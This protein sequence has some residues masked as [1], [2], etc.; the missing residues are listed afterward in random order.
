[1]G[2]F[3]TLMTL[4]MPRTVN[5]EFRHEIG[6]R[7][8]RQDLIAETDFVIY[9]PADSLAFQKEQA[10]SIIN[11]IL[12][13]D[14]LALGRSIRQFD[15]KLLELTQKLEAVTPSA[16]ANLTDETAQEIDAFFLNEIGIP[17]EAFPQDKAWFS[18]LRRQGAYLIAAALRKGIILDLPESE[19]R[20]FVSVRVKPRE[21]VEIP[22]TSLWISQNDLERWIIGQ[23]SVSDQ[24]S[25]F[26]GRLIGG[27]IVP[28][29]RYESDWTRQAREEQMRWVSPIQRRVKKGTVILEKGEIVTPEVSDTIHAYAQSLR[30]IGGVEATIGRLIGRF[31]LIFLMTFLMLTFLRVNRPRIFFSNQR[32]SL[33]LTTLLLVVGAMVIATRLNDVA[34]RLFGQDRS[35]LNLSYIFLAP[36]CIVPIFMSNFF[37]HRV[38][39]FSNLVVTFCGAVLVQVGLEYAF[40]QLI[41]GTVAVYSLRRLRKR[42]VFFYTLGFIFLGYTTAYITFNLFAKGNLDAVNLNTILLFAINVLLT[43]IAYNLIYLFEQIFRVTSDLTYLELLDTNH[44]LLK[45]LARKAPGTFQHSLQVANLAEAAANEIG[46]NALLIHVG[47]LYHDIGKMAHPKYFIENQKDAGKKEA[48]HEKLS[49]QESAEM[50]IEHVRKGVTIAQKYHLP[51]ELIQFIQTHH[52]TT[53]VEYFYRMYLKETDHSAPEGEDLFRYP[54]PLPFS[55]ETAVLMIADSV[56]AAARSLKNP[57]VESLYELVDNIVDYKISEDQLVNSPLT[58]YDIS[59][60]REVLKE[61]MATIYHGRIEYPPEVSE[62]QTPASRS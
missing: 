42:E 2:G 31:F 52:G 60:I 40:V 15:E 11:P 5:Q 24:L 25:G 12:S 58:F 29:L 1:M 50:I 37:D 6:Q 21:E 16:E 23:L 10:S 59:R 49:C 56:E 32:L 38:A 33:V 57:T 8:L 48:P 53:R 36:A 7:W 13:R 35:D 22:L 34:F 9:K 46:G 3:V 30:I 19:L 41:A 43:I 44:P 62:D 26:L 54:G 28:D 55:K 39:F 20:D 14:S 27:S 18:A 45:E 47:A 51:K 17:P 4:F 61:Q